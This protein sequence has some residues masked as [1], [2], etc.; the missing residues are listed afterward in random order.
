MPASSMRPAIAGTLGTSST[1]SSSTTTKGWPIEPF[2]AF[3]VRVASFGPPKHEFLAP[4][5]PVGH[6]Q[7][8][9]QFA[10]DEAAAREPGCPGR[11][12]PGLS[13]DRG[14]GGVAAFLLSLHDAEPDFGPIG[15]PEAAAM[16]AL[17]RKLVNPARLGKGDPG[18]HAA[19]RDAR[20]SL[21]R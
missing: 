5:A 17:R 1:S 15:L 12:A 20:Q 11:G 21:F 4:S 16:P 7:Y 3:L 10:G 19:Q 14:A 2:R 18:K 9:R 8:Q 6:E 13:L